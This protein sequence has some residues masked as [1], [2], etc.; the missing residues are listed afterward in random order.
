MAKKHGK[1]YLEAKSL[2]KEESYSLDQ[3]LDL[4]IKTSTTKFDAS[5]EVH[6]NLGVDPKQADQNIRTSTSLP[7]GTG[8]DVR[9][10]AFVADDKIKEAKAAGAVEAG[11]EELVKKIEEGWLEFDIAVAT[12]DQMKDLAKIAKILGQKRLMPSPKSGTVTPEFAKVIGE[13]KQGKVELRVDKEGNLHNI[14]GKVSFGEAKLKDNLKTII[15]KIME[16]KPSSQKGAY[17][18]SI[19]L[20]TSM[21]PGVPVDVNGAIAESK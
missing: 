20:A 13:L 21:G 9:V 16:I 10:V 4:L 11:T 17:V 1:K 2:V 12:P 5:C 19:T 14:F 7:N 18:R 8:K 6:F 15:K 3:A